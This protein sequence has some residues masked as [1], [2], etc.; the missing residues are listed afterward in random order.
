MIGRKFYGL[1]DEDDPRFATL[2]KILIIIFGEK[3]TDNLKNFVKNIRN[4]F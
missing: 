1:H 3:L 2:K 4:K